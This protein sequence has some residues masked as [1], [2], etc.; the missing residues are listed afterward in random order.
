MTSWTKSDKV[1]SRPFGSALVPVG[2]RV[3]GLGVGDARG[4]DGV[5]DA[6]LDL[7]HDHGLV[8]VDPAAV[9]LDL[10]EEHSYV[11]G[12]ERIADLGRIERPGVFDRA[13]QGQAG[14]SRLG[15]V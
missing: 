2:R 11:Q 6:V 14:G 7:L 9:E 5:V 3:H 8:D 1:A 12:R 15:D 13:L 4:K 10:P